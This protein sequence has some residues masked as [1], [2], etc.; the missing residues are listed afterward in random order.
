MGSENKR[1]SR[2][3]LFSYSLVE[4]PDEWIKSNSTGDYLKLLHEV[5][6]SY[7]INE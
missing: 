6:T 5:A 1:D 2:L 3:L 4:K 7:I